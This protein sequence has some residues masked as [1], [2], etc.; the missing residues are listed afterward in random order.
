MNNGRKNKIC[1]F[2]FAN[3]LSQNI[4]RWQ[5]DKLPGNQHLV[6]LRRAMAKTFTVLHGDTICLFF[7]VKTVQLPS[8]AL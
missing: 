4:A 5:N 6:R 3:G 2:T 8:R 1:V 7:H